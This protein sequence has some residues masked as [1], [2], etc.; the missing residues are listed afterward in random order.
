VR[1]IREPASLTPTL[2]R[3]ER[4]L[5]VLLL[6]ACD[7]CPRVPVTL[8][9]DAV[10]LP[11]TATGYATTDLDVSGEQVALVFDTAFQRTALTSPRADALI[12]FGGGGQAGPLSALPLV[13]PL[14]AR[15]VLGADVLHQLPLVFDARARTTTVDPGARASEP[16]QSIDA[17]AGAHAPLRVADGF[18]LDTGSELTLVHSSK[19]S[20]EGPTLEGVRVASGFAG[21]FFAR[22]FRV[23]ELRVAGATFSNAAVLTA[24]EIDRELDRWKTLSGYLGWNAL[25][26]VKVT[27]TPDAKLSLDRFDT[28]DHW[29]RDFVGVG[30]LT[31]RAA[32]GLKVDGFLSVSPARDAGLAAGDV[33]EAID[34]KPALEATPPWGAPGATLQLRLAGGK[35]VAVVVRDLL[36]DP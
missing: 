16:L 13:T 20:P 31:S 27:L 3:R 30:V 9:R 34:G 14:D 36:P 5:L 1:E 35:T 21:V 24:P 15:G 18:A 6:A 32:S 11:W 8:P 12:S 33:I 7:P 17:C 19:F 2:S 26:E 10:T 22:A 23:K 29:K 25:R 4:G 28:Q